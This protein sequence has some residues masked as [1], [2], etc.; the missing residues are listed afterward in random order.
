[1]KPFLFLASRIKADGYESL[2]I[3]YKT[4]IIS[5]LILRNQQTL[6]PAVCLK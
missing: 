5:E 1:M 4:I 6:A 2:A 3:V